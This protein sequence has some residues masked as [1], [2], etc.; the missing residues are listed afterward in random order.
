MGPC[1]QSVA[2]AS[3]TGWGAGPGTPLCPSHP[4]QEHHPRQRLGGERREGDRAVV[5]AGG[6]GGL[7]ELRPGLDLRV[8]VAAA[9]ACPWA[10][11]RL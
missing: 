6:A 11:T 1:L 5:P 7:Q 10:G 9:L 4:L 8:T 2:A 3:I